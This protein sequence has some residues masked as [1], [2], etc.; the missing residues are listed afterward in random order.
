MIARCPPI[1]GRFR[2][3]LGRVILFFPGDPSVLPAD[4]TGIVPLRRDTSVN[5]QA[6]IR[7]RAILSYDAHAHSALRGMFAMQHPLHGGLQSVLERRT[8]GARSDRL[9]RRLHAV[10]FLHPTTYRQRVEVRRNESLQGGKA[11]A[12]P[13][14]R[15]LRRDRAIGRK[16]GTRSRLVAEIPGRRGSGISWM[17][18]A[19]HRSP[20][21]F[22]ESYTMTF[23]SG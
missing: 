11:G 4:T 5:V 12:Q 1:A 21:D 9:I 15:N 19:L 2:T 22:G 17:P 18:L 16:P 10:L 6:S 20:L 14:L 23:L 13:R 3:R 7:I 8:S